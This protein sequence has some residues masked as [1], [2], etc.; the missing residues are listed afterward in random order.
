MADNTSNFKSQKLLREGKRRD[1]STN[2]KSDKV[3]YVRGRI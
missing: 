2:G 1:R 3:K